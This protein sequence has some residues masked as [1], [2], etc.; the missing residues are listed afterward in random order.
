M[1][2]PVVT[3]YPGAPFGSGYR[4]IRHSRIKDTPDLIDQLG[5][6]CEPIGVVLFAS[7]LRSYQPGFHQI[8]R[9]TIANPNK[10]IDVLLP[11]FSDFAIVKVQA[12]GFHGMQRYKLNIGIVIGPGSSQGIGK[13]IDVPPSVCSIHGNS[14]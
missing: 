3:G 6:Y 9:F 2:T 7:G 11:V 8:P 10:S 5:V 4:L 1:G 13:N 12:M 14:H